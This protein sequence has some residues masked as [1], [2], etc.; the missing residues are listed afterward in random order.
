[1]FKKFVATIVATLIT[2]SVSMAADFSGKTVEWLIP[3]KAG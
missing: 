3:F 1:M 2:A